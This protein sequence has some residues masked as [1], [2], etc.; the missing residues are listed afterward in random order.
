LLNRKAEATGQTSTAP[1]A[2]PIERFKE[3]IKA[4]KEAGIDYGQK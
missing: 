4:G 1:K 2:N 3:M